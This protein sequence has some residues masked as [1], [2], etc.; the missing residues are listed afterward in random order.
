M[1][2]PMPKLSLVLSFLVGLMS[3]FNDFINSG[4]LGDDDGGKGGANCEGEEDED[5]A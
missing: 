3:A 4:I 2:F 5:E 1:G